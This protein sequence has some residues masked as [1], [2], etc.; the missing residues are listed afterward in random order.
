[1]T[2]T[3]GLPAEG[4]AW[5]S[6]PRL[7]IGLIVLATVLT[8][9]V[10][11]LGP[12]A[13]AL[14]LGPRRSLL[15][16]YYLPT[17]LIPVPGEWV[18]SSILFVAVGLGGVGLAVCLAALR[19]GWRPRAWRLAGLGALLNLATL[20]VPPMTSADVLMYA[21]YGRLQLLGTDPYDI[22]PAAIFRTEYDP[23]LRWTE[24]P[25]TDTPSVYGPIMTWVQLQANRLGGENMHDIVFWLQLS[26]VVPLLLTGVMT[27]CLAY[28]D[29]ERQA[30]AALLTVA[31]P[32]LIWAITAGAHNEAW[33]VMFA[34][35]GILLMRRSSVATGV[36][37]GLAGAC[38][39]SIGLF[40]LAMLWGYRHQPRKLAGLVVGTGLSMGLLYGVFA[41]DALFSALRNTSYVSVGSWAQP[42]YTLLSYYMSQG[43]AKAVLSVFSVAGTVTVAA[44]LSRVLPWN[45]VAGLPAGADPRRDPITVTLR[46]AVV[47]GAGWLTTSMYTLSWYDLIVWAPMALIG[48][49]R[50]DDLFTWRGVALSLSYIPGRGLDYSDSLDTFTTRIRDTV[51][52]AVQLAVLA[53]IAWWWHRDLLARRAGAA[54]RPDPARP[55]PARPD[56]A[57]PDRRAAR[58]HRPRIPF[59]PGHRIGRLR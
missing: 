3:N 14:T 25:W 37:I 17:G 27:I 39:L 7:G 1:M 15:P 31:N 41:P 43:A 5:T 59:P 55:D 21:A 57:R 56:P 32:L 29:A 51:S 47:L 33:S 52:P 30:R 36:A 42:F 2:R 34:M 10:G 45:P 48:A 58:W 11:A 18:V 50:L 13:V 19:A 20:M 22:T 53:I 54:A 4:P 16:P 38:K 9:G 23:V 6:S 44:M 35:A 26:A 24:R 46:T 49:S 28:G 12:S 40:G 8:V